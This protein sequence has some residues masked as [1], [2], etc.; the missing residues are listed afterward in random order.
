LEAMAAADDLSVTAVSD[1]QAQ[2]GKQE[3]ALNVVGADMVSEAL[4]ETAAPAAEGE[5]LEASPEAVLAEVEEEGTFDQL[6]TLRPEVVTDTTATEEEEEDASGVKGK[7]K[8]KKKKKHV[9]IEFDPD[10]G[11]TFVTKKHKRGGEGWDW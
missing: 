1:L 5:P 2:E 10:A 9:E 3:P 11:R 8:G 7:K 4:L 6:F